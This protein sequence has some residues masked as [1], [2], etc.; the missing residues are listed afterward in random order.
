MCLLPTQL[1]DL[2]AFFGLATAWTFVALF[3]EVVQVNGF[4]RK[5]SVSAKSKKSIY[6]CFFI[7]L[8]MWTVKF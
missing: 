3:S 7:Y 2:A 5:V 4:V 6:K 8:C 1:K